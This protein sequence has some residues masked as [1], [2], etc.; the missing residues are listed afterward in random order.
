MTASSHEQVGTVVVG[1]GVAGTRLCETLREHG[2]DAPITLVGA[3]AHPPYSRPPLSKEVLRGDAGPEVALLRDPDSLDALDLD[4]RSG[5]SAL[6]LAV[7][8]RTVRLDDGSDVTGE[9]VVIATGTAVRRIPSIDGGNVH[10]L[11][12]IDDCLGLRDAL[13]PGMSVTIVG[14]GFI[15][16][17]VAASARHRGCAVTVIDVLP[18]P[19]ARVVDRSV[20][21]ALRR[22]H[23]QHGVAFRLGVAVDGVTAEHGL[24]SAVR[25]GDGT[26]VPADLVVVAIGVHPETGWLAGSGLDISDGVLCDETLAAAPGIWAIGDIARWPHWPDPEPTRVE[27]WTNAFEQAA[28]VATAIT[29]GEATPYAPL[30]YVWSD[31]YDA[32]LQI[33]GSAAGD[34]TRVIV[35]SLDEPKWVA[36]VRHGDHLAGVLGM[37]SAGPVMRRRSLLQQRARWAD[38]ITA[39]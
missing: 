33:L 21:A 3:E 38:V 13:E 2:Y 20:G 39:T 28:V 34:E 17:E 14:A 19:L 11:R 4:L 18:E 25:L 9:H 36:L 15:G 16:L 35:G 22:M 31:Q 12:T 10:F 30:P 27:H 24:V 23:E 37:R 5:V 29:S 6:S 7:P 32:K 26:K 1:A 8:D